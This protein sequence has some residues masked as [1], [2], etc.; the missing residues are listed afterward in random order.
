[1]ADV[2]IIYDDVDISKDI[3]ESLISLT[4]TD[5]VHGKSDEIEIK[6]EDT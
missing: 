6:L 1:M 4:Y 3:S 5:N 2:K